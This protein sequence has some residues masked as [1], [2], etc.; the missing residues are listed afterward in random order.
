VM[1][2]LALTLPE[3]RRTSLHQPVLPPTLPPPAGSLVTRLVHD[4][5]GTRTLAFLA[6]SARGRIVTL[7]LRRALNPLLDLD[8]S[9][10]PLA[11]AE[12]LLSA[13]PWESP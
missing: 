9:D 7:G 8:V 11:L 1:T 5:G 12:V 10:T 4:V 6:P 13:P 2:T 3:L